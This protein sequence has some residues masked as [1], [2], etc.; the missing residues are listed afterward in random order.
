MEKIYLDYAASTPVDP[1]VEKAILP[2]FDRQ[3]GNPGS[4]HSF[5]REAMKALDDARE[6][7]AGILGA[8]FHEIIFTGSA[9]E[10]NNLALRG[11]VNKLI[12]KKVKGDVPNLPYRIIT[13]PIEHESVIQTAR[14]LAGE[15]VEVVELPVS[16]EGF[17]KPE[18]LASALTPNT[19]LVSIVYASN[20]IGTIQPITELAKIVK[21]YRAKNKSA[22]PL[23]HTDA[24]QALQ[25]L[26][27]KIADLGVDMLTISSQKIYAL[28]GAGAL[29]LSEDSI[30]YLTGVIT[31]GD[32]EFGLRAATENVPAI[33]AMAKAAEIIYR[34][35]EEATDRIEKLRNRFWKNLKT[36]KPELELNGP[37]LGSKRLQNNL[38]VYFPGHTI[39][40]L[41]VRLDMAGVA[42]SSGSAC[43]MRANQYSY[44]VEAIG[45]PKE[46]AKA[47]LRFSLGRPTT[48]AEIDT[49]SERIIKLL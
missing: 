46:R 17:V 4:V 11:V 26:N 7:I 30:R 21:E 38:H 45:F 31:G 41:M 27:M 39:D 16:K 48:E 25:F 2:Y 18:D 44:V 24:V 34:N 28:K 36:A 19:V 1:E 8:K 22:Y 10:A 14:D 29:Y 37:E 49:A 32:Q 47:S 43:A 6:I 15:L 13:T 23:F 9:T 12:W 3:F 40:E 42:A 35:R 33:V 5:G 20:V